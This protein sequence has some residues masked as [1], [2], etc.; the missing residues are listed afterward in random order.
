MNFCG[1]FYLISQRC[2]LGVGATRALERKPTI[3]R[4]ERDPL[5]YDLDG[6]E[7]ERLTCA[8]F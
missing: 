1:K 2:C 8:S 7:D 4:E 6:V 5:I 3:E